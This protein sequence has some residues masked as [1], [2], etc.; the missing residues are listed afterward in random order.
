MKLIIQIPCF[1][2]EK[3]LGKTLSQLPKKI[4]GITK[5]ET[6]IIND[7][8]NDNTVSV[9]KK[10]GVKHIVSHSKRKGLSEA[11]STGIS[12]CLLR[13]ADIIV[14]T[15][16][17]NQYKSKFIKEL[18][19]PI[20]N[21]NAEM[22]IGVRNT[23]SIKHFSIIKKILQKFGSFIVRK[24]SGTEVSDTTSGFRAINR[25]AAFKLNKFDNYTYTLDTL[26]QAGHKNITVK[27]IPIEVNQDLRPSK[28][29]KSNFR[30]VLNNAIGIIRIFLVYRPLK[31][32]FY[33]G[34]LIFFSGVIIGLRYVYFL[35]NESGEGNI[36]SLILSAV[37]LTTG[38]I[39][40]ILAFMAD[41][42]ASNRRLLEEITY[43][44]NKERYKK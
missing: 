37:L 7:G 28:L 24:L 39:T 18:V 29:I 43:K 33:L 30:Y 41:L 34:S 23:D 31:S 36:Q 2:E 38:F 13:G 11:F 9:A 5:I 8:S 32:F 15:D 27:T 20:I 40:L 22:V 25:E 3:I 4:N 10:Y 1:N 19:K 21:N 6:L 26:I 44:L 17:D 16:A 14:N 35:F 42:I 12:E